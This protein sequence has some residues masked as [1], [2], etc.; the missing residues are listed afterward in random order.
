MTLKV[1]NSQF[2]YLQ[3]M[4]RDLK[5]HRPQMRL[6]LA[7]YQDEDNGFIIFPESF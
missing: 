4:S 7:E 3:I 2:C 6:L 1:E 5:G